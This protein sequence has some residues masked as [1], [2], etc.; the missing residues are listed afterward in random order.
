MRQ[1]PS[2]RLQL[3]ILGKCEL[4]VNGTRSKC[5]GGGSSVEPAP[6]SSFLVLPTRPRLFTVHVCLS[7]FVPA[8]AALDR[9]ASSFGSTASNQIFRRGKT[10]PVSR[11]SV[12]L[13]GRLNE[14]TE[15]GME[16]K[17]STTLLS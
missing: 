5:S 12:F 4:R 11:G 6:T 14:K 2:V 1:V 8:A 9:E 13:K 3:H 16:N 7:L 10:R 15:P 17:L